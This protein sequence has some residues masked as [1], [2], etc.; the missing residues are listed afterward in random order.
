MRKATILLIAMLS[1]LSAAEKPAGSR[2]KSF[3]DV[4]Y[5]QFSANRIRD[6]I[7]N[8]GQYVSTWVTG[9]AGMTW[10][11]GWTNCLGFAQGIWLI[12][13]AE[14][15]KLYSACV[16]FTSENKPGRILDNRKPDDPSLPKYKVY[17]IGKNYGP[18]DY[19]AW[20]VADGAPVDENGHPLLLG[21]QT[22]W[23]VC[24]DADTNGHADLWKTDPVGVESQ[25]TLFG[26]D[27]VP[28]LENTMFVRLRMIHKGT[29]PLQ[30]A[31]L[32]FWN[33]DDLGDANDDFVG[34]DTSRQLAYF[35]N[36]YPTDGDFGSKIPAVGLLL[37]QGPIVPAA[38]E[39]ARVSGK[40][41][42]DCRN[43]PITSF[44]KYLGGSPVF[45]DPMTVDEAFNNL[46][47]LTKSAWAFSDPNG[48]PRTIMYP[49]DPVSG[50]GWTA[51]DDVTP[52]DHR[53]ITGVGPFSFV[54]GD[55]QEVVFAVV[56]GR[57]VDN[58]TGISSLRR[59]CDIIRPVYE[60]NFTDMELP[61]NMFHTP[62]FCEE[63]TGAGHIQVSVRPGRSADLAGYAGTVHY[64]LSPDGPVSES[65]VLTVSG[66]DTDGRSLLYSADIPTGGKEDTIRYC[67][68]FSGNGQDFAYPIAAPDVWFETIIGPD[69][70]APDLVTAET[71]PRTAIFTDRSMSVN[72][73]FTYD[74]RSPLADIRLQEKIND[75]EWT[76]IGDS[77]VYSCRKLSIFDHIESAIEVVW[78]GNIRLNG[79]TRGDII[80]YRIAVSDSTLAENISYT[81]PQQ[82][83]ISK[84]EDIGDF[85]N[86]YPGDDSTYPREWILEGWK[87]QGFGVTG[88][89]WCGAVCDTGYLSYGENLNTKL[90][91]F[92]ALPTGMHDRL[93]L[94]VFHYGK[95]N[96]NDT[97]FVEL[98]EDS[99]TWK[100][101]YSVTHCSIPWG[102]WTTISVTDY[103]DADSVWLRFR[104]S[105]DDSTESGSATWSINRVRVVVDSTISSVAELNRPENFRLY[106][107][108]PNPFNPETTLSYDLPRSSDVSV[109]IY[110]LSGREV[111]NW[112]MAHQIQGHYEIIWNGSDNSGAKVSSGLYFY[113]IRAGQFS[114]TKKMIFLK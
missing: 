100:S 49:G 33:D 74:D 35:Y 56:V 16:E 104:F 31:Y 112:T 3:S 90:S 24:N 28:G 22:H 41:I 1:I 58:L 68:V 113:R 19:D 66:M 51:R 64:S 78:K 99:S 32:G 72:G 105:S 79:C 40:I 2:S 44:Q 52:Q 91:Y 7:V 20:P 14:N 87:Y 114:E 70:T 107:N 69:Q 57:G 30:E 8:N 42:P 34:I 9:D 23:F 60:S 108:F 17:S 88:P 54:P 83:M 39:T 67:F 73:S 12:G 26:I 62:E 5:S 43:L 94:Q 36:G 102:T 95:I 80:S 85:T 84:Q 75:G 89:W 111:R 53:S 37:L 21:S 48:V 18:E 13:K 46:Q 50:I 10:P 77:V 6:F 11:D 97:G 109:R 65:E 103:T 101:V 92:R 110:D 4:S 82:I 63:K 93:D 15:E 59:T 55:T 106:Q 76:D 29:V 98:S 61:V 81:D 86:I 38:G 45:G 27:S 96:L 25:Y 71:N 47:G